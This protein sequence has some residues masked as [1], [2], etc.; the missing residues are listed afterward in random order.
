MAAMWLEWFGVQSWWSFFRLFLYLNPVSALDETWLPG[1]G[2]DEG[3]TSDL[4]E[5]DEEHFDF[6]LQD[7]E[8]YMKGY[9]RCK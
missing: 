7:V 9:A 2:S 3:G 8:L 5:Y 6:T 1:G 4:K